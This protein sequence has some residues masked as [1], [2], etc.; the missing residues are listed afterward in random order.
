MAAKEY[1]RKPGEKIV[2][3]T[4]DLPQPLWRAAKIRAM[5]EGTDLRSIL[6]R[7]LEAYLKTKAKGGIA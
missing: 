5:D 7:A 3:T 1:P 2:R 4:L 6:T